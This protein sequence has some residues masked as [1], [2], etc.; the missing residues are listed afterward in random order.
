MVLQDKT[1][2][3]SSAKADLEGTKS[4]EFLSISKLKAA[5]Y[6]DFGLEE[7]VPSLWVES[8]REY[9]I[10]ES[11]NREAVRSQMRILSVISVKICSYSIFKKSC[12]NLPRLSR[13]V[14]TQAVN[15]WIR[16]PGDSG[17]VVGR[18]TARMKVIKLR[19]LERPNWMQ[20]LL[21]Q[22]DYT[23][24]P[25]PSA[26]VYSDILKMEMEMEI[27]STSDINAQDGDPLQ[28]DVRLCLGDDLKK[29]QDHKGDILLLESLLNS[30]PSPSLNQGN[31]L[32]EIR[33]ELKVCKSSESL[34]DE[35]LEVEL[36]DLPPH[37]EYAF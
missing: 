28:D 19:S 15:M 14:L 9:D 8:E 25:K 3:R 11:S 27:R 32:P 24:V 29:A 36:K 31:Y 37:L 1:G 26:G 30:D 13:L 12:N 21:L 17:I 35:P 16:N 4:E 6:L 22:R 18:L 10:S 23:I 33:K 2:K 34:I 20:R 7:L 5:R